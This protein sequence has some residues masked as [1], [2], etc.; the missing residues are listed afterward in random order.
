MILLNF[1]HPFTELQ[2][3][4]LVALVGKPFERVLEFKTQFDQTESFTE[5]AQKLIDSIGLSPQD[6]QTLPILINL[7]SLNVITALLLAEVHGRMG[8]FPAVVRLRP[9]PHSLPPQFEVA[10]I[11][12]LQRVRD[13]ARVSR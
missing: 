4:A 11:L 12:N 5:Q 13:A 3:A 1:A 9:I 8:Y 6:W 10:E 2:M 7:P